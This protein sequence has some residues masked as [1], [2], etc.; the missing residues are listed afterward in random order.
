MTDTD[1]THRL[2]SFLDEHVFDPV[3][4]ARAED[5]PA[6]KRAA[7]LEMQQAMRRERTRFHGYSSA[8]QVYRE[9]HDDVN[10]QDE[11]AR[12]RT[13]H[14]L[15]LPTLADVRIDFEQM[16]RDLEL[17]DGRAGGP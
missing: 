13:L 17:F 10:S 11:R 16:A 7:L 9:F 15:G 4:R 3:L 14:D 12:Q 1:V 5:L 6:G 8:A 2:V